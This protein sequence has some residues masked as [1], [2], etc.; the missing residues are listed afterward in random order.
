MKQK[1]RTSA[2]MAMPTAT[3]RRSARVG[4]LAGD[5]VLSESSQSGEL[6]GGFGRIPPRQSSKAINEI[7]VVILLLCHRVNHNLGGNFVSE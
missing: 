5:G 1:S 4:V 3:D 6:L 7:G 2:R